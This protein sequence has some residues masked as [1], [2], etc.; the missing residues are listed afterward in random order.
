MKGKEMQKLIL[1]Q[2]NPKPKTYD[3]IAKTLNKGRSTIQSH[4]IPLLEKRGLVKRI[5]KRRQAWLF[6]ITED[7]QS[8]LQND[9]IRN[10]VPS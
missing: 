5:G 4:Y 8:F 7:G 9:Y 6:Q 3:E 10:K 2:L 1:Q